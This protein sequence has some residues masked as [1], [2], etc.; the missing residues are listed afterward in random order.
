MLVLL[1]FS[2]VVSADERE[3]SID[4]DFRSDTDSDFRQN[5]LTPGGITLNMETWAIQPDGVYSGAVMAESI[6]EF[7]YELRSNQDNS[8]LVTVEP[9]VYDTDLDGTLYG[10]DYELDADLNC[11][12]Y[13]ASTFDDR[14]DFTNDPGVDYNCLI[15]GAEWSD[16]SNSVTDPY[17]RDDVGHVF[18][19]FV[20]SPDTVAFESSI[21]SWGENSYRSYFAVSVPVEFSHQ[22]LMSG[23]SE[24]WVRSPIDG[25]YNPQNSQ[26]AI[27]EIDDLDYIEFEV[28]PN[29]ILNNTEWNGEWQNPIVNSPPD[30]I[31][32]ADIIHNNGT[33]IYENSLDGQSALAFD[34]SEG[35]CAS[36]DNGSFYTDLIHP[37]ISPLD[38]YINSNG[39]QLKGGIINTPNHSVNNMYCPESNFPVIN[40]QSIPVHSSQTLQ[41]PSTSP[42]S[43]LGVSWDR[44]YHRVNSFIYPNQP[45]LFVFFLEIY[46]SNPIIAWTPEDINGPGANTYIRYGEYN[47]SNPFD[48][49]GEL[50]YLRNPYNHY[51]NFDR[52]ELDSGTSFVFT[53]GQAHDMAGY[54]FHADNTTVSFVKELSEP[55][56]HSPGADGLFD[57]YDGDLY[58]ND[59][60]L[61]FVSI[62][63]PFINHDRRD[64]TI[65]Y[66]AIAYELQDD[67][68]IFLKQWMNA[69]RMDYYNDTNL[70]GGPIGDPDFGN[71]QPVYDNRSGEAINP[72]LNFGNRQIAEAKHNYYYSGFWYYGYPDEGLSIISNGD[73]YGL[74]DYHCGKYVRTDAFTDDYWGTG[75]RSDDF[76]RRAGVLND[77]STNPDYFR[78][79]YTDYFLHTTELIPENGTT[80]ILYLFKFAGTHHWQSNIED[81]CFFCDAMNPFTSSEVTSKGE[82]T[83]NPATQYYTGLNITEQNRITS[84]NSDRDSDGDGRTDV[85][86]DY[87]SCQQ[88]TTD[89]T[90]LIQKPSAKPGQRELPL[91]LHSLGS[92]VTCVSRSDFV[93]DLEDGSVNEVDGN[94]TI[95]PNTY[96]A[97]I[98]AW[99]IYQEYHDKDGYRIDG[100]RNELIVASANYQ[101]PFG[102]WCNTDEQLGFGTIN[103]Y[104][105]NRA[106]P[107]KDYANLGGSSLFGDA[108]GVF[109]INGRSASYT[110]I[111]DFEFHSTELMASATI[112]NGRW[113]EVKGNSEGFD[114]LDNTF[115]HK[116]VTTN[117][118]TLTIVTT[119]YAVPEC[120]VGTQEK[121]GLTCVTVPESALANFYHSTIN[122]LSDIGDA[123]NPIK[124]GKKFWDISFKSV[125]WG[126]CAGKIKNGIAGA[127]SAA[128]STVVD[129]AQA[130]YGSIK[131][132]IDFIKDKLAGLGEFIQRAVSDA[133]GVIFSL[134]HEI[135]SHL[136][137]FIATLM[138]L[139]GLVGL[140][141]FLQLVVRFGTTILLSLENRG[142]N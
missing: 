122:V 82:Y 127:T 45:Y 91:P 117:E 67:G 14:R 64:I 56:S 17:G 1:I 60:E 81:V 58:S 128:M 11:L 41:L 107:C 73:V 79:Q 36:V 8:N 23:A 34:F 71:E 57:T 38:P 28:E 6:M 96:R 135:G 95:C 142:V 49:N 116:V 20:S 9:V 93:F 39:K 80:H 84:F 110:S 112:T 102:L 52:V 31:R 32:N 48:N 7:D 12:E 42:S 61:D 89:I 54:R 46:E 51:T 76:Q 63:M 123:C 26:L 10:Y 3:Q 109:E 5:L 75:C 119:N 141:F 88:N 101:T 22:D 50:Q 106:E 90:L 118:Y 27:F 35:V 98:N 47:F 124:T 74:E 83:Y 130:I 66:M 138:Y 18:S 100:A 92:N 78:K 55:I 25:G 68:D 97:P 125:D 113:T 136:D 53:Q 24:F 87:L 15:N 99:S 43:E 4:I 103:A 104:G 72:T 16:S 40:S 33:L 137:E 94:F 62:Y 70:R 44:T 140:S 30:M 120:P 126:D 139:A 132:S 37:S 108:R 59:D 131:D 85:N 65:E 29:S 133:V 19:D 77:E 21:P 69:S 111:R 129:G 114:Y 86:C 2:P 121:D 115:R 105:W 13:T 134:F